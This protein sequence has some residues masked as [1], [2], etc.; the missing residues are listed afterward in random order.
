MMFKFFLAILRE[1]SLLLPRAWLLSGLVLQLIGI[2]GCGS[3]P[4]LP[5]ADLREAGWTVREGQAV[6]QRQR[7]GPGLAGEI[8]VATRTNGVA[9]VQFT[10]TP[11]PLVV[12]QATAG[13]WE[14]RFPPQ[15]KRYSGRGE[16]PQRVI[17]LHLPRAL[18][19][20]PPPENWTWQED[21]DGW[22]LA[23]GATGESLEGYFTPPAGGLK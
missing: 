22:R 9:L 13:Q 17:W 21:N 11:F 10:K 1:A 4:P 20:K 8:L 7:G 5:P 16:P 15:D 19:G 14:V 2:T 12:A 18:S 3:V 23:N 6:W